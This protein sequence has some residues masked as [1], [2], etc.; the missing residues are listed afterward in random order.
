MA[1]DFQA[2][3]AIPNFLLDKI[4]VWSVFHYN[5]KPLKNTSQKIILF[6]LYYQEHVSFWESVGEKQPSCISEIVGQGI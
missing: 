3:K 4:A 5:L 6:P 2:W 1:N